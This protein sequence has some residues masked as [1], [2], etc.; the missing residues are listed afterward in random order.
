MDI[1]I[2]N[3]YLKVTLTTN[4]AQIKSVIRK[5][6]GVEHIVEQLIILGLFVK[7]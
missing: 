1:I 6:D 5:C 7:L 2:E 4:G 3:E